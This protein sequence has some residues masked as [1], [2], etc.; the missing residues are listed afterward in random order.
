[1]FKNIYLV[2]SYK[3]AN[4][5]ATAKAREKINTDLESL[6]S[7]FY[8]ILLNKISHIFLVTTKL[9]PMLLMSSLWWMVRLGTG[10]AKVKVNE[11]LSKEFLLKGKAQYS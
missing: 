8:Q 7:Y 9:L 1:M 5:Q 10:Q 4:C 3:I 2:K 6:K 11:C